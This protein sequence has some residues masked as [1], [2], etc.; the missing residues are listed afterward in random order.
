M[1]DLTSS[2]EKTYKSVKVPHKIR[3][4]AKSPENATTEFPY[5]MIIWSLSYNANP[6]V[7]HDHRTWFF[8]TYVNILNF[9]K[10]NIW[11]QEIR[12]SISFF[13]NC[14]LNSGIK[15]KSESELF[16][17]MTLGGLC[18]INE[19]K[20]GRGFSFWWNFLKNS[21]YTGTLIWYHT[22]N[23]WELRLFWI[24][25]FWSNQIIKSQGAWIFVL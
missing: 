2:K 4:N 8:P 16:T 20:I 6:A 14:N 13:S 23:S 7:R 25:I 1:V 11:L 18:D 19:Q 21:L 10:F 22:S 17:P 3:T 15:M 5:N 9:W 12:K 24:S